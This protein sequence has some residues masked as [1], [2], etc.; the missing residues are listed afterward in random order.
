MSDRIRVLVADDDQTIRRALA[1][2]FEFI[3]DVEVVGEATD[4]R[5]AVELARRLHPDVVLMDFAMP[6]MDGIEATRRI[7]SAQPAS[8]VV[9]LSLHGHDIGDQLCDAG[10]VTFLTKDCDLAVLAEAVRFA[11]AH[12]V[13]NRP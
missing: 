11:A 4:G 10:A 5:E 8:R 7:A 13:R 6:G 9:G 2:M 1:A 3:E 12:P